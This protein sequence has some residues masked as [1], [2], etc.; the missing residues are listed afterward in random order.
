MLEEYDDI[1]TAAEL[2]EALHLGYNYVYELLNS[3]Q[4]KALRFG[5]V[6]RIPKRAVI[7][8]ILENAKISQ[9]SA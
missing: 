3:G 6:W 2:C 5:R 1:M 8:F 4:I 9:G 7:S